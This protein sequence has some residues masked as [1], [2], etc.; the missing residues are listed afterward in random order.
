MKLINTLTGI[1]WIA[2]IL[3]ACGGTGGDPLDG[4]T[5]EL[6]SIG[7]F[8]PIPGSMTTI[9]FENGQVS[10]LGGCNQYGGEYQ[11]NG[12]MIT[13]SE[14]YMTEMAC[15]SPE[16]V[17]EQEGRY[18]QSLGEARRFELSEGQ[19]QLYGSDGEALTFVPAQ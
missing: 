1:T 3:V 16:G 10:G 15:L 12:G 11:V 9:S 7:R 5:W 2:I 8:S 14:L 4:T 19:L 18:L 13:I 17:M 6:H